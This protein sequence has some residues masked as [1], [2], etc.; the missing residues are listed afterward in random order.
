MGNQRLPKNDYIFRLFTYDSTRSFYKVSFFNV[1]IELREND[2]EI[3]I[4]AIRA[5]TDGV[6]NIFLNFALKSGL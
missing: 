5:G 1:L 2:E 3:F 6:S 4:D